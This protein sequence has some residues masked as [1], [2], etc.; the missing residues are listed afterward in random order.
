METTLEDRSV[1]GNLIKSKK[2]VADHGEV[3][4]PPWLVEAMLDLTGESD[5]IDARFLEPACGNGNF[6]IRILQRK[7]AIV[8]LKHGSTQHDRQIFSLI[9]VMSI[10]GIE[11]LK[12]NVTECRKR[13]LEIFTNFLKIRQSDELSRAAFYVLSQNI[14][15]GDALKMRTITDNKPIIFAEWEYLGRGKFRRRDFR[16][17]FLTRSLPLDSTDATSSQE[18]KHEKFSPM[19][20]KQMAST[21]TN[22]VQRR[23]L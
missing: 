12:D 22:G 3:F 13:M 20:V 6:L 11:L 19:T 2:R 1:A 7:L 18:I 4:T 10:Y 21:G 17:D 5:R 14:I 15:H 16:F 9:A 23:L 8:E